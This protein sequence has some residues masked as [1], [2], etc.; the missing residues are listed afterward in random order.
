MSRLIIKTALKT[1][2]IQKQDIDEFFD[3]KCHE[4]SE[5]ME[6]LC[7]SISEERYL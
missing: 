7:N 6:K 3:K 4:I 5:M 1:F 2:K